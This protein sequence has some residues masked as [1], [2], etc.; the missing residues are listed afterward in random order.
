MY[1]HLSIYY[2]NNS[3][4]K[5][6]SKAVK[7]QMMKNPKITLLLHLLLI[8]ICWS[9]CCSSNHLE[10]SLNGNRKTGYKIASW[11]CNRGLII[12]NM[13]SESDKLVD[14]KLFIEADIHGP[15]SRTLRNKYYTTDEIRD[16]LHID[17]YKIELPNTWT[18]H[19]QARIRV[20]N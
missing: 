10:H 8:S 5:K 7:Q 15:G 14:I 19:N 18:K 3:S 12:N 2:N 17:G 6:K 11:N 20:T 1:I 9:Y 16:K 4:L 13:E